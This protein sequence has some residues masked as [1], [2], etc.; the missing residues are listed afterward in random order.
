M[1][2]LGPFDAAG[3]SALG[4]TETAGLAETVLAAGATEGVTT[5]A[6]DATDSAAFGLMLIDGFAGAAC[7]LARAGGGCE[8]APRGGGAALGGAGRDL[9]DGNGGGPPEVEGG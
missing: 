3:F 7:S 8:S 5:G 2:P 1:K 9:V 4:V 6:D